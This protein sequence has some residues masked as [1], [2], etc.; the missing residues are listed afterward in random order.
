MNLQ[1]ILLI[2]FLVFLLFFLV[3]APVR[4]RLRASSTAAQPHRSRRQDERLSDG[5]VDQRGHERTL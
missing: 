1:R 3:T 2:L 4:R 5:Q